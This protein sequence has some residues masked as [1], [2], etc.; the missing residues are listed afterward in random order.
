MIYHFK[1]C[2]DAPKL[3]LCSGLWGTW[4]ICDDGIKLDDPGADSLRE[5]GAIFCGNCGMN[6][7]AD[8]LKRLSDRFNKE[9]EK[10]NDRS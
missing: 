5:H 8:S 2:C 4:I 3:T 1:K 10:R 7:P 9:V 6:C